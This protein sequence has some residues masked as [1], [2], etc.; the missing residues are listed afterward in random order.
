MR[1][2]TVQM[3]RYACGMSR[4]SVVNPHEPITEAVRSPRWV[5]ASLSLAMFMPSLDTSIANAALPALAEAFH[6]SFEHVQWIVLSY[7]LAIT[8]LIVGAGRLGDMLGRRRL[9]SSG[10]ALF[11]A[12]SLVCGL[13]PSLWVLLAARAAQ[14]LGGALMIA[15]T[16]AFVG[17]T[18]PKTKTGAA[19]GLLGT[20]SAIGTTLGPSVGGLLI[21]GSGWRAIFLVNVPIGIAAF[22]L[23]RRS[24]PSDDCATRRAE[25]FDVAGT[26]LLALRLRAG[27]IMTG[28]VSTVMMTTLV[29]GPFYLD[30]GLGL[31]AAVVGFVLSA[32][33]LVAGLAG[34]PAGRIV[35]RIGAER[36]TT[37]GLVGIAGGASLLAMTR[38]GLGIAGYLGPIV[39]MTASYALFQAAN[40][41]ALMTRIDPAERGVVA[42][43][44]SLSRNLGLI[45]GASAM[46]AIFARAVGS[47]VTTASADAVAAGTRVT[48]AAAAILIGITICARFFRWTKSTTG[49]D[50]SIIRRGSGGRDGVRGAA[51]AVAIGRR[52]S[53]RIQAGDRRRPADRRRAAVRSGHAS[54]G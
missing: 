7:L 3:R 4:A 31:E 50:E 10:I 42:G 18:V 44:L 8:T 30:R 9:L 13:A 43:M 14:G 26:V 33:P 47:G 15:L 49:G 35:D 45:T 36:M 54:M 1:L 32:G 41:T 37:I 46:G 24:L 28:L 17:D 12:A 48:F 52:S 38:P 22:A 51:C 6:A 20:M 5:L 2:P 29:V 40:N 11:T 27:L 19:M 53:R 25:R 21:A 23:A 34:V 39:V 16:L